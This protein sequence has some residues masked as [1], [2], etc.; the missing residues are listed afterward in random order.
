MAIRERAAP[1]APKPTGDSP[2]VPP[3][4]NGDRLTRAEFERRYYAM[5]HVK[6]A[7]LIEG[8]VYM[9]SPVLP[10]HGFSHFDLIIWLG[11]YRSAAPGMRGAD[12]TSVRLDLGNM[13]QPDTFLMILPGHGGQARFDADGHV[14]GAP[15]LIA[16]VAASSVSYDL[17]DKLTAYLRNGVR[18]YITW[19][20]LDQAIDWRV[21]R[22]GRYELLTPGEDGVLRSEVF[23]GLWL[24]PAA[25]LRGELAVV[26]EVLQQGLASPAH[27]AFVARLQPAAA[28]S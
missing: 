23:P 10:D 5:P 12:N 20:V 4:E 9:P 14:A 26:L 17:N 7:E 18:E 19:R 16:E 27:A 6:K 21:L 15:E 1:A 11:V 24:A 22:D 25:L 28:G 2:R 13:P 3:L 8:V